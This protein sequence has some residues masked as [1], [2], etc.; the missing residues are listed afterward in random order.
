M[1]EKEVIKTH[2]TTLQALMIAFLSAIFGVIGYFIAHIDDD[3][4]RLKII[5]GASCFAFLMVALTLAVFMYVKLTK[6]LKKD[7]E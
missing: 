6:K 4:S 2:I 7:V 5:L 3:F 1:N